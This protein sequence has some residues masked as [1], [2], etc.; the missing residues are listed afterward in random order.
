MPQSSVETMRPAALSFS[1]W[2]IV[3][4]RRAVAVLRHVRHV[5]VVVAV[6]LSGQDVEPLKAVGL[7]HQVAHHLSVLRVGEFLDLFRGQVA[8]LRLLIGISVVRRLAAG[9]LLHEQAE[10][11]A[12]RADRRLRHDV[13]EPEGVRRLLRGHVELRH[14]LRILVGAF[15]KRQP[16]KPLAAGGLG[17]EDVGRA[18]LVSDLVH[19]VDLAAAKWLASSR[20]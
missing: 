8:R 7:A 3:A 5:V 20:S 15:S 18:V 16:F 1:A 14:K 12:V 2:A 11:A 17:L 13:A 19:G 4:S 9:C 10:L 6:A